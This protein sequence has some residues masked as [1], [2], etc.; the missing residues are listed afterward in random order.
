MTNGVRFKRMGT[1]P[2]M[3]APTS[4]RMADLELNQ[5]CGVSMQDPQRENLL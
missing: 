3:A 5:E 4:A 1:E 2:V